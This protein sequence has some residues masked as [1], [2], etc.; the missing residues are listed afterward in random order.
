MIGSDDGGYKETQTS[1]SWGYNAG[2]GLKLGLEGGWKDGHG[3]LGTVNHIGFNV[4]GHKENGQRD[5]YH[6]INPVP[7]PN[8]GGPVNGSPNYPGTGLP[9]YNPYPQ[10][11]PQF[12]PQNTREPLQQYVQQRSQVA[13]QFSQQPYAQQMPQFTPQPYAPVPQYIPQGAPQYFPQGT[14]Q[15]A[16]ANGA[17][18]EMNEEYLL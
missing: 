2:V 4:G 7:A 18:N 15:Y 11:P 16:P 13:P 5:I 3:T 9:Y 1:S 12:P 6:A 14:Q 8:N 10:Y 17:P